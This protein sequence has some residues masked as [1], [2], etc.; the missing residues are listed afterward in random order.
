M[1]AVVKFIIGRAGSGKTHH[2]YS[3]LGKALASNERPVLIVPEQFTFEAEAA[4]CSQLG[5]LLG[6]KV[7]S[8]NR[9]SERASAMEEK[10]FISTQGRRMIVRRETQKLKKGLKAFAPVVS[11]PGFAAHIDTL[12]CQ[13]RRYLITPQMLYDASAALSANAELSSKLGDIAAI[14]EATEAYLNE[15]Y[16]DIEGAHNTL[17]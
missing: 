11:R 8:F 13:F 2:L 5:G 4:L 7:L 16:I 15:N 14:Y 12:L 10:P 17:L 9:L 1:P 6:V 3:E